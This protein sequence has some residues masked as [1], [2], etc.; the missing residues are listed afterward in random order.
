MLV[1]DRPFAKELCED[2]ALYFNP[3]DEKDIAHSILKIVSDV[4]LQ[5]KLIDNGEK[6][7]LKNY[8]SAEQKWALQK[9]LIIEFANK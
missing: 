9:K 5:K 2:A 1:S 8:P 3:L 4:N 7:L 6:V